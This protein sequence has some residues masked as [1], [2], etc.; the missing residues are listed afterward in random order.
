MVGDNKEGEE[1]EL[2]SDDDD[3]VSPLRFSNKQKTGS[4]ASSLS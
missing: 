3:E 2:S 4:P 1:D